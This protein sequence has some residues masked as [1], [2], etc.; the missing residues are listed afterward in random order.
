MIQ[1]ETRVQNY[2]NMRAHNF[3]IV[4][5]NELNDPISDRWLSELKKYF[6][7]EKKLNILDVG[8]GSG[9]FAILQ[10]KQ[11]HNVIGVDLT[12]NMLKEASETAKE[13]CVSVKFIQ[14][15]AQNLEFENDTFDIV[16]TRNLTWTLPNPEQAYAEW[17]RVLKPG[18]LFLN[19]DANYAEN[20]RNKNQSYS[21]I[22][23]SDIYG[24]IGVTEESEKEN[25]EI[26]LLMP[27]G[28]ANRP[29]WDKEIMDNCGFENIKID[30]E[31]GQRILQEHDL[32]DA[33]MFLIYGEKPCN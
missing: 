9:Y 22:K 33:P 17:F 12:E 24:H 1:L 19:F 14:M 16:L 30:L 27:A 13:H 7:D 4:R 25:A 21:Y 3:A 11:G 2:W 10:A 18:G 6:S 32:P 31:L 20:V 8:T 5:E 23:P 26:T 28:N 15:D 29:N